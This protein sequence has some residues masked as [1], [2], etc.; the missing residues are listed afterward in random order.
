MPVYNFD[1]T[2]KVIDYAYRNIENMPGNPGQKVLVEMLKKQMANG[3]CITSIDI[4]PEYFAG[5]SR[6]DLD[7]SSPHPEAIDQII[8][9]AIEHAELLADQ[10]TLPGTGKG[11][12]FDEALATGNWKIV[13]YDQEGREF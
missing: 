12:S 8:S 7:F 9:T 5:S 11:W 10:S 13:G 3:K 6:M 1:I 2:E 4:R